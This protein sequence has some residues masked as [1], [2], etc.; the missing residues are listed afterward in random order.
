MCTKGMQRVNGHMP[1]MQGP[2]VRDQCRHLQGDERCGRCA[3]DVGA[4]S[5]PAIAHSKTPAQSQRRVVSSYLS[6]LQRRPAA[7]SN[8]SRPSWR[9]AFIL[10]T[11][12]TP[13]ATTFSASLSEARPDRVLLVAVVLRLVDARCKTTGPPHSSLTPQ[14]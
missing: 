11:V 12:P 1:G 4:P 10:Q 5:L 2:P 14:K 6:N 3:V 9:S 7:C 8:A 13:A